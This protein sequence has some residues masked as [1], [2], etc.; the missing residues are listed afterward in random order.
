MSW[1]WYGEVRA[2]PGSSHSVKNSKYQDAREGLTQN[3]LRFSLAG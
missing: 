1:Q 2:G 3:T